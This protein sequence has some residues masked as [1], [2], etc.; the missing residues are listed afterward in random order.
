M[1]TR[2][3]SVRDFEKQ[4]EPEGKTCTQPPGLH[5]SL[6]APGHFRGFMCKC[7]HRRSLERGLVEL[8]KELRQLPAEIGA[9]LVDCERPEEASA[10]GSGG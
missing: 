9:L 4:F 10:Q 6:V 1:E 5:L 7:C 2:P 8:T 3:G